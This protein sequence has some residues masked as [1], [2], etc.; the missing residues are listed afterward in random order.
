MGD[1]PNPFAP[2]VLSVLTVSKGVIGTWW[3]NT[4]DIPPGWILCDGQ[5][6]TPDLR[7][8]FIVAAGSSH[9]PG[10]AG[11]ATPHDHDFT[12]DGHFHSIP[13]NAHIKATGP[14]ASLTSTDPL[15]GTTDPTANVP[16]YYALAYIMYIG[17]N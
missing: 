15:A 11:G 2:I 6:D 12:A 3:G 1:S 17:G 5:H 10:A 8:K 7:D 4:A 14:F 16:P 13:T 9:S